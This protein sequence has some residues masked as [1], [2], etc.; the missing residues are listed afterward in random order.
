VEKPVFGGSDLGD[1]WKTTFVGPDGDDEAVQNSRV[2]PPLLTGGG[3]NSF[4]DPVFIHSSGK[5][6][7][8]CIK[9]GDRLVK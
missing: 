8:T 6:V 3:Q 9:T 1:R 4:P 7:K 2:I 5:A